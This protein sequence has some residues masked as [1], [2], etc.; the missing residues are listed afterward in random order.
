MGKKDKK[1]DKKDKKEDKKDDKKKKKD[2]VKLNSKEKLQVQNLIKNMIYG[3]QG[4]GKT[5]VTG[6]VNMI[7]EKDIPTQTPWEF[8]LAWVIRSCLGLEYKS[9]KSK[10]QPNTGRLLQKQERKQ[11][12]NRQ[13]T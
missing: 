6:W 3:E 2:E 7:D 1:D 5:I 4:K 13:K 9:K 12:R 11:K 10:E 8:Q